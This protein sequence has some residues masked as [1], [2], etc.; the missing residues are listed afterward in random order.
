MDGVIVSGTASVNQAA[1][2]GE[3]LL[4]DR[5]TGDPVFAGTLNE[6]GA[7]ESTGHEGRAGDNAGHRFTA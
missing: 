7:L 3:S 1:I 4:V 6:I 5:Q 2:T